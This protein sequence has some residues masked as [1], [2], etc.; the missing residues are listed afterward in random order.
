MRNYIQEPLEE[1]EKEE[2]NRTKDY[3]NIWEKR[4]KAGR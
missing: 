3:K 4:H 1:Q 2:W